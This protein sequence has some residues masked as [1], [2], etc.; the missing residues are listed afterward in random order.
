M[1]IIIVSLLFLVDLGK[2]LCCVGGG[3][4]VDLGVVEPSTLRLSAWSLAILRCHVR[5]IIHGSYRSRLFSN[6]SRFC[7]TFSYMFL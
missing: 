6:L 1:L 3:P 7:F 4:E 2:M 5:D